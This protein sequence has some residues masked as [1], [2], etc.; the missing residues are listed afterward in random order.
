MKG[1][2]KGSPPLTRSYV[3]VHA[4][5]SS[6]YLMSD[7]RRCGATPHDARMRCALASSLGEARLGSSYFTD[8]TAGECEATKNISQLCD[9]DR[10]PSGLAN[11][12]LISAHAYPTDAPGAAASDTWPYATEFFECVNSARAQRASKG[13]CIVPPFA[14]NA[15]ATTNVSTATFWWPTHSKQNQP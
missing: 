15:L 7:T 2:N 11:R 9:C 1:V 4:R 13:V 8:R 12:R 10:R 5:S 6:G 14:L 3:D